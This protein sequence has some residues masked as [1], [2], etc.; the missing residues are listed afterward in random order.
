MGVQQP[1]FHF[2]QAGSGK[3]AV[4]LRDV[5]KLQTVYSTQRRAAFTRSEGRVQFLPFAGPWRPPGVSC[6]RGNR[7]I[8]VQS[9]D[10][11]CTLTGW[12]VT[13][14]WTPSFRACSSPMPVILFGPKEQTCSQDLEAD[15]ILR[16]HGSSSMASPL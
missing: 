15:G 4:F 1:P 9:G 8:G 16:I 13:L 12:H 2:W 6:K 14:L 10:F 5:L 11:P 7:G 3:G